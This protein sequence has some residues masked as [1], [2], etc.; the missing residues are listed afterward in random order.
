MLNNIVSKIIKI[1]EN[2]SPMKILQVTY[3]IVG[4]VFVPIAGMF[5]LVNQA[6]GFALLIV[7]L[8]MF[9][10]LGLNTV[11]WALINLCIS[12]ACDSQIRKNNKLAAKPKTTKGAA[13]ST[14]RK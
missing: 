2:N 7:P 14:K 10:A 5:A 8:V 1:A 13:A 12:S 6:L 11:M 4:V 3:G 9:V